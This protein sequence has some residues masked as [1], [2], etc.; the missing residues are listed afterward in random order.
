MTCKRPKLAILSLRIFSSIFGTSYEYDQNVA[1]NAS[2]LT[3]VCATY[4]EMVVT[5]RKRRGQE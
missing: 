4:D 1:E 2:H 5:S 3:I